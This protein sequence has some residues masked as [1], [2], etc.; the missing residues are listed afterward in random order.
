MTCF[1][2]P[3][4]LVL[5]RHTMLRGP[6]GGEQIVEVLHLDAPVFSFSERC[7]LNRPSSRGSVPSP[8]WLRR[9][10]TGRRGSNGA[11]TRLRKLETRARRFVT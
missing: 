6:G 3:S 11:F 4:A 1:S 5:Y 7:V 9:D 10:T 2:Y 8:D